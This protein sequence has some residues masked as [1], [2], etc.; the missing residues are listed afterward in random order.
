MTVDKMRQD[1][2]PA[3]VLHTYP[4]LETSLLVETFTRNLGRVPLVAKGAKRPKSALRGLLIA[5]QP[6][7]LTWTGKSELRTLHKAEWQG[8]QQPLRGMALI[9]GFYL[10]E[11]LIRLLHRDDPH[12]QLFDYYQETLSALNTQ[13]DYTPILRHFERRML[14][15]L[16]YA[17]TLNE[18]VA[19]GKPLSPDEE[20]YYEVERG[21]MV[22]NGNN[23]NN[24][25]PQLRGK[26]LLDMDKNNYSDAVTRQQSKVLMRYILRHYLGEQPLYSRQLLRIMQT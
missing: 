21:P 12:E 7:Q 10:N 26:T 18:D 8:G 17:L 3:F 25:C 11:L 5:F 4:Y 1:A 19:S 20:Y 23:H 14:I 24:S 16:G 9:C 15:E 2:Q 6:L 13:Q 22:A